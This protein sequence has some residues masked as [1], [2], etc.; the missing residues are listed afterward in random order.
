MEQSWSLHAVSDDVEGQLVEKSSTA[1]L[2]ALHWL[3]LGRLAPLW[4]VKKYSGE[5]DSLLALN[6]QWRSPL[7]ALFLSY[8]AALALCRLVEK[9]STANLV[10]LHWLGRL[11]DYHL[12]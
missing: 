8:S 5:Y 10:A 9:S 2:V 1:N 6:L 4:L 12:D 7:A 11:A 3:G